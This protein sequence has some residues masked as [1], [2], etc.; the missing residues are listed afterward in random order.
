MK[1]TSLLIWVISP[2]RVWVEEKDRKKRAFTY[3]FFFYSRIYIFYLI[4][5]PHTYRNL[6]KHSFNVFYA[7]Q[8][9]G[10]IVSYIN[11]FSSPAAHRQPVWDFLAS[12]NRQSISRSFTL[13][14]LVDM[15]PYVYVYRTV[16]I[17]FS[18]LIILPNTAHF[19]MLLHF[20]SNTHVFIYKLGFL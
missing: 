11:G 15:Y 2:L 17:V 19:H 9:F 12:N 3:F 5:L 13:S 10:L 16:I 6:G 1:K 7:F 14:L 4:S 18:H 8:V 20:S